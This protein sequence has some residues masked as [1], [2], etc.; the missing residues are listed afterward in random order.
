M[1]LPVSSVI[2]SDAYARLRGQAAQMKGL[3]QQF[4]TQVAAGTV[5][6]E[7]A[8]QVLATAI[9]T[10]QVASEVMATPGLVP[11]AAMVIGAG[12]PVAISGTLTAGNA[13]V[14]ALS[15]SAALL[16]GMGV[17]GAN[18][19]AGAT[20]MALPDATSMTLSAAPTAS[21]AAVALTC[22]L[23]VAGLFHAALASL[24]GFQQAL[25]SDYPHDATTGVLQD[26]TFDAQ[27]N[28]QPARFAASLFSA[29][30]SAAAAFLATLN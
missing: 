21:G 3:V 26:R 22:T 4:R 18:V 7:F 20:I 2:A 29:S 23:D 13:T 10:Q 16:M 17:V 15:S 9:A 27:G 30:D 24:A 25:L 28:V 5:Y 8:L 11:Y 6:S 1:P 19:P 14:T 12:S